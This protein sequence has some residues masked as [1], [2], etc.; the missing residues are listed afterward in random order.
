MAGTKNLRS[1]DAGTV[2]PPV[3]AALAPA[4]LPDNPR[5]PAQRGQREQPVYDRDFDQ[6]VMLPLVSP[7]QDVYI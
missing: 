5:A 7:A 4:R 3:L 2:S 1:R 6:V